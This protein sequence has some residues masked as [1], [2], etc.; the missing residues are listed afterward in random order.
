MPAVVPAVGGTVAAWDHPLRS[1]AV[2]MLPVQV[3]VR[4][5]V[6]VRPDADPA[7]TTVTVHASGAHRFL[8]VPVG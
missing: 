7:A 6:L 8:G 3:V 2:D 1:S 4:R 5:N